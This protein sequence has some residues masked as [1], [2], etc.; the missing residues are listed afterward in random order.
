M[1]EPVETSVAAPVAP[2][3]TAR[4]AQAAAGAAAVEAC[5]NCGT[6][7]LGEYCHVCGQHFLED[8]LQVRQLWHEL[9][10]R[11]LN[12]DQ[13][14]VHAFVELCRR[15]GATM[16][17]YVRGQR[18]RFVSPFTYL[19]M[20]TAVSLLT[21]GLVADEL[22]VWSESQRPRYEVFLTPEQT[23]AYLELLLSSTRHSAAISLLMCL[24]FAVLLRA[25]F[26]RT[27]VNI[28][29]TM[30]FSLFTLGHATLLSGLT[31]PLMFLFTRSIGV[32]MAVG[33]AWYLVVCAFAAAGFF[34]RRPWSI[35]K[36]LVACSCAYL[37]I[38]IGIST[39]L[40]AYVMIFV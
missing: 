4:T 2:L 21:F 8:R 5:R 25:F 14:L 33:S 1:P 40:I 27:G 19:F 24:P 13:G 7:R 20:G 28:A 10:A 18:R 29:E 16:R 37:G 32:Y 9:V 12:L 36:A 31:T 23:D 38:S 3:A 6:D 39:F 35:F 22:T 11:T 34:D 17:R 26:W 15:P 30:V